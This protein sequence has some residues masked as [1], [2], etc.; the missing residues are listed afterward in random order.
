MY[1]QPKPAIQQSKPCIMIATT[2]QTN[3]IFFRPTQITGKISIDQTGWFPKTSGNGSKYIMVWYAHDQYSILVE[4]MKSRVENELIWSYS[5]IYKYL[6][7]RGFQ[8]SIKFLDNKCTDGL[9][10]IMR[11]EKI[12]SNCCLRTDTTSIQMENLLAL[13]R[14]NV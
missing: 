9:K 14:R 6:V 1:Q 8:P 4:C 11:K 5:T 2:A 10:K 7:E 13:G 3:K 12:V